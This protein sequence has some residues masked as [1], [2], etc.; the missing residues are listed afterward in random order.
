MKTAASALVLLLSI[1]ILIGVDP[2]SGMDAF[3]FGKV[4]VAV[5]G[6]GILGAVA[7]RWTN[8]LLGLF[9]AWITYLW[10][11]DGLQGYGATTVLMPWVLVFIAMAVDE[12][13]DA[14]RFAMLVSC[15]GVLQAIYAFFQIAGLDFWVYQAVEGYEFAGKALGLQ[16]H[17]TALSPFLALSVCWFVRRRTWIPAAITFAAVVMAR[18]SMGMLSLGAGLAYMLWREKPRLA[19][20]LVL[21]AAAG[22]GAWKYV[23]PMGGPLDLDGRQFLWPYAVE[24]LK[25]RPL[26]GV[27]PGA[28]AGLYPVWQVPGDHIWRHV[29]SDIL[30]ALI[31]FG[32][33]G[34][35]L[36]LA[37]L[38][39]AFDEAGRWGSWMGAWLAVLVVNSAANFTMHLPA[40][41]F[42]GAWLLVVLGRRFCDNATINQPKEY[43]DGR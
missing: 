40:L 32:A 1:A 25:V 2:Q 10:V 42:V 13:V 37:G 34:G 9:L 15:L 20:V 8:A 41:G 3:I 18:S 11:R 24:A 14:E 35:L 17:P 36:I 12:L 19:A 26:T 4:R 22:L 38:V 28:W 29:H 23:Q 33:I 16:G 21:A 31:E 30:E 39:V 7:L 43:S 6:A 27:G 5:A